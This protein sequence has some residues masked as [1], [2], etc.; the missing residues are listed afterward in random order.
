[1]QFMASAAS[2][3]VH[4]AAT[5]RSGMVICA[6]LWLPGSADVQCTGWRCRRGGIVMVTVWRPARRRAGRPA[7]LAGPEECGDIPGEAVAREVRARGRRS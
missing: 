2:K 6:V 5:S 3:M 4:G 7:G 1:M